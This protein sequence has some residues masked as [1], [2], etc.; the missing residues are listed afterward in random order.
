M[1]AYQ[2]ADLRTRPPPEPP[3]P[4]RNSVIMTN[5]CDSDTYSVHTV[6]SINSDLAP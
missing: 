1:H 5:H 4:H 6:N 2:A 3:P